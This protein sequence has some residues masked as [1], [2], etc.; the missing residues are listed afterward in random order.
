M[1]SVNFEAGTFLIFYLS[2]LASVVQKTYGKIASLNFKVHPWCFK[3]EHEVGYCYTLSNLQCWFFSFWEK[4]WFF[5]EL[6]FQFLIPLVKYAFFFVFF[7]KL[8][9]IKH[10]HI[11]WKKTCMEAIKRLFFNGLTEAEKFQLLLFQNSGSSF[12]R[13]MI[14]YTVSFT[15]N[16]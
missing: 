11:V 7:N 15:F 4:Y 16:F 9:R 13:L 3:Q 14:A 10:G 1:S 6:L 12:Q 5:L 8:R 2:Y